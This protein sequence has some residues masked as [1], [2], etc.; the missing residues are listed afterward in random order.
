MGR[1]KLPI[2]NSV[3]DVEQSFYEALQSGDLDALMMCWTE[4]DEAVCVHP[5]GPRL[6][7][8]KAVRASF[9]SLFAVG[10]VAV[11]ANV[12]HRSTWGNCCV[13]SVVETID[14]STDDG[15]M[16]ATVLA[17]NVYVKSPLGWRMLVHHASP[18]TATSAPLVT[19]NSQTL[20]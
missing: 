10:G 11:S 8:T 4:D 12:V 15:L 16:K 2:E 6:M 9:A 18:G 5:G 7:G 20:H 19:Q 17:T 3:D 1:R 13:H 14:L